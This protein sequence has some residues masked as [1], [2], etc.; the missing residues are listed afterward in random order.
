MHGKRNKIKLADEVYEIC[1]FARPGCKICQLEINFLREIH[2]LRFNQNATLKDI[3]ALIKEKGVKV[4][5]SLL[6]MHY[7]KHCKNYNFDKLVPKNSNVNPD[8]AKVVHSTLAGQDAKDAVNQQD[9]QSA[10]RQLVRMT[11]EYTDKLPMILRTIGE[12]LANPQELQAELARIPITELLEKFAKLQKEARESTRDVSA[13]RAP[14]VMV[15]QAF[16]FAINDL[17]RDVSDIL[18]QTFLEIQTL[19]IDENQ[20]NKMITP[21]TFVKLFQQTA[22]KYKERMIN[23]KREKITTL[24]ANLSEMEKVI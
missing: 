15:G 22:L 4:P 13:M 6:D 7:L 10:Y 24:I 12:R 11:A 19:V 8:L 5:L 21:D 9:I 2:D 16:E 1:E 14:K 20:H 3:A 23:L 18:G 17:I